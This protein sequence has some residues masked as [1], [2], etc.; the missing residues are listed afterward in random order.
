MYRCEACVWSLVTLCGLQT[1]VGGQSVNDDRWH[2]LHIRRRANDVQLA[3]GSTL[4]SSG[5]STKLLIAGYLH[6]HYVTTLLSFILS[7]GK[8]SNS[9]AKFRFYSAAAPN[10]MQSAVLATAIPSVCP[11]VRLSHAG[12]VPRRMKI[13]SSGPQCEVAKTLEFSDTNNGWGAT[14][15]S[16]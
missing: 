16:T 2:S 12:I 7:L 3:V 9:I 14:S 1:L 15:S 4:Q 5:L 11:F 10:A 6:S 13:G 8:R